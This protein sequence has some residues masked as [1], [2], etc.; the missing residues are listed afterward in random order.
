MWTATAGQDLKTAFDDAIEVAYGNGRSDELENLA[1]L[2]GDVAIDNYQKALY[3]GLASGSSAYVDIAWIDK[4]PIAK[5]SKD[6]KGAE[7]GDMML[8]VHQSDSRNFY[9]S[10]AWLCCTNRASAR[11]VE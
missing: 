5:L 7:L 3:K 9:S 10:R 4:R 8:V 6:S 11:P 1:N 2:F